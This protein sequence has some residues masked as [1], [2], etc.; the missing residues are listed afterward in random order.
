MSKAGLDAYLN[1]RLRLG[2]RVSFVQV[3][4]ADDKMSS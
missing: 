4:C 3:S 2:V 1:T